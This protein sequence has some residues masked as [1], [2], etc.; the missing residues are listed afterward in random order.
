L[1]LTRVFVIAS[2]ENVHQREALTPSRS[3]CIGIVDGI[4]NPAKNRED[5]VAASCCLSKANVLFVN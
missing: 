2:E 3:D 5:F 1:T 4:A